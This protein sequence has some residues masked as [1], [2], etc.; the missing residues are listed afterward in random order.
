MTI[1]DLSTVWV[2]S[3]VPESA[4]RLIHV[5]S[6]VTM[7][8]LAYPGETF[9]AAVTRIA[10]VVDRQ[11]RTI[12]VYLEMPNP[13]GSFRPEMFGNVR[14]VGRVRAMPVVPLSTLVQEYGKIVIFIDRGAGQY[15]RREVTV[16]QRSDDVVPLI[17]GVQVGERVIVDG[18]L[19]LKGQ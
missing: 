10:D 1:A 13:H 12:K 2:S 16:G 19:L 8:L 6:R 17:S 7:T 4:I 14:H 11:T 15:E 3:D 18:A 9:A 5:G